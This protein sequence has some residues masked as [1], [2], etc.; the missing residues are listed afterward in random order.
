[1][2]FA[3]SRLSYPLFPLVTGGSNLINSHGA[4]HFSSA[5]S[6]ESG[7]PARNA[8][9]ASSMVVAQARLRAALGRVAASEPVGD[10][11]GCAEYAHGPDKRLDRSETLQ[12]SANV[13]GPHS[14]ISVCNSDCDGSFLTTPLGFFISAFPTQP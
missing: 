14:G 5:I 9:F 2:I 8:A 12:I 10:R 3:S 7:L 6:G 11:A 13:A 4:S 1:M